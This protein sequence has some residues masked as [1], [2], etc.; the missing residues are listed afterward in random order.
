LRLPVRLSRQLDMPNVQANE[1]KRSAPT[2]E[3]HRS[4]RQPA[5]VGNRRSRPPLPVTALLFA[6]SLRSGPIV[7]QKCFAFREYC[8]FFD[9]YPFAQRSFPRSK[10]LKSAD[11]KVKSSSQDFFLTPGRARCLFIRSSSISTSPCLL[12]GAFSVANSSSSPNKLVSVPP[13]LAS[14]PKWIFH[15]R[16]P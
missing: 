6:R 8:D 12:P 14:R 2:T 13:D 9:H 4:G 15:Q 10:P 3:Y 16:R 5:A 1:E 7:R 11:S